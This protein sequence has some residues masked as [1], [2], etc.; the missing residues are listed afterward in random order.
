MGDKKQKKGLG[1]GVFSS[2]GCLGMLL[3][4]LL[5]YSLSLSSSSTRMGH[6]WDLLGD[7]RPLLLYI[8]TLSTFPPEAGTYTCTKEFAIYYSKSYFPTMYR[9]SKYPY[10]TLIYIQG[11]CCVIDIQLGPLIIKE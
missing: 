6:T 9:L 3:L 5:G 1:G 11:P 7:I 8:Q 10:S 2:I 4:L